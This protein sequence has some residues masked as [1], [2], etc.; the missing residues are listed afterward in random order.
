MVTNRVLTHPLVT[1]VI[2]KFIYF[3]PLSNLLIIG[4]DLLNAKAVGNQAQLTHLDVPKTEDF[5]QQNIVKALLSYEGDIRWQIESNRKLSHLPLYFRGDKNTIQ[6]DRFYSSPTIF[7]FSGKGYAQI[8]LEL[9]KMGVNLR[10]TNWKLTGSKDP[11][12]WWK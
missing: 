9:E 11:G 1:I 4:L 3:S 5:S 12:E 8:E 10:N 6:I 7:G 2:L